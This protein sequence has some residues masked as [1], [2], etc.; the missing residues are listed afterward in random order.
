M[1]SIKKITNNTVTMS[2]GIGL[3]SSLH[4][5]TKNEKNNE[6]KILTAHMLI[7]ATFGL[8]MYRLKFKK[9]AS[10]KNM[11]AQSPFVD[12]SKTLD[13]ISPQCFPMLLV[14]PSTVFQ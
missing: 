4:A 5:F 13:V 3:G 7:N 1:D 6:Q 11:A 8:P 14:V 2:S 10:K 9:I 12:V